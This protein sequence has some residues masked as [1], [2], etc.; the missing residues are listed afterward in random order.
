MTF[1]EII[2]KEAVMKFILE[3][4][5]RYHITPSVGIMAAIMKTTPKTIHVKLNELEADGRIRQI[6]KIKNIV[7]FEV[8]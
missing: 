8:L 2:S 4:H 7:K 1:V 6:K 5:E 3:F